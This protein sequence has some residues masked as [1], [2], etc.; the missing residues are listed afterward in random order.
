MKYYNKKRKLFK[1]FKRGKSYA[2]SKYY[3]AG[4]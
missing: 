3:R 2:R 1:C 4:L